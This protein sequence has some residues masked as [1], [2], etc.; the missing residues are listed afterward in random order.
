MVCSLIFTCFFLLLCSFMWILLLKRLMWLSLTRLVVASTHSCPAP[1]FHCL[2]SGSVL[3]GR[4]HSCCLSS[5]RFSIDNSTYNCSSTLIL[6]HFN[7]SLTAAKTWYFAIG[8]TVRTEGDWVNILNDNNL[9]LFIVVSDST[10][11]LEVLLHVLEA[12]TWL[13]C[14]WRLKLCASLRKFASKLKE[15]KGSTPWLHVTSP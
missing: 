8:D 11:A 9:Q 4:K 14:T 5:S 15:G 13:V 3:L 2:P 6:C 1:L 12:I 10:A 7:L